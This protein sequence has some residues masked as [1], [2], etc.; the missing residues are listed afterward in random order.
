MSG[1]NKLL[2][3]VMIGL[4]GYTAWGSYRQQLFPLKPLY[5]KPYIVVY[6]R[7]S[8]GY[9]Q[10]MRKGL[11][12]KSIP[13]VWKILDEEPG[14]S[15]VFARMKEAGVETGS[16]LLPVVDV[17]AEILVHPE[18]PEVIVKYARKF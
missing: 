15:E 2:L 8:C 16:F 3:A 7:E 18:S 13:Y 17:N 14:R 5:Q 12:A 1:L 4:G 11:E 10:A 9:C 6:G